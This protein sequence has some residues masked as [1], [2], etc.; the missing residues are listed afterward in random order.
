ME[1]PQLFGSDYVLPAIIAVVLLAAILGLLMLRRKR[2]AASAGAKSRMPAATAAGPAGPGPAAGAKLSSAE[3]KAAKAAAKADAKATKASGG[4]GFLE[5]PGVGAATSEPMPDAPLAPEAAAGVATQAA[6]AS[7]APAPKIATQAQAAGRQG[8]SFA[9]DPLQSVLTSVL[10]GWGDLTTEDTNRLDIFRREKVVAAINAVELPKDTKANEYARTRLTQLKRYA[11]ALE[12]GEKP[13]IPEPE[14]EEFVAIGATARAAAAAAAAAAG[15]TPAAGVAPETAPETAA[16]P[17]TEPEAT[18]TAEPEPGSDSAPS[19]RRPSW[20]GSADETT[21]ETGMDDIFGEAIAESTTAA[22]A[23]AT[24]AAAGVAAEP[25]EITEEV[26]DAEPAVEATP[27]GLDWDDEPPQVAEG[28]LEEEEAA[29]YAWDARID[30]VEEELIEEEP[31]EFAWDSEPPAGVVEAPE[32]PAFAEAPHAPSN[33]EDAIAAAAAAFW[34]EPEASALEQAAVEKATPPAEAPPAFEGF[35]EVEEA[36]LLEELPQSEELPEVDEVFEEVVASAASG[37]SA[38]VESAADL[39]ALPAVEQAGKLAFL[40]PEE[41][42]KVFQ[43]TGDKSL[44]KSVIDTL[45][46]SGSTASLDAIHACLEDPDPE[47][48][49]Y[50]LDAADRLLGTE[51]Q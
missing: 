16:A 48:Q 21:A 15:E 49:L 1:L 37:A 39:L 8:T 33:T 41:L 5:G 32:A 6:A 14:L 19:P 47:I 17:T 20:Y 28:V 24:D 25:L 43:T 36:A 2:T 11:A 26:L 27:A 7:A 34:A 4:A 12:K 13:P 10:Q 40:E 29:G 3:R 45:E 30:E 18:P 42:N 31:A 9:T 22:D 50:A 35:P 46:H 23:A 38:R 44:K 51:N